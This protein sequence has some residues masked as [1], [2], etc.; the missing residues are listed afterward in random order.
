MRRYLPLHFLC[1]ILGAT[2]ALAQ[3]AGPA[4]MAI[5]DRLIKAQFE[6]K[7][8]KL[9]DDGKTPD[10]EAIRKQLKERDHH[11]LELPALQAI[12]NGAPGTS[13]TPSI[14]EGRKPSVLCF[15][16]IYKCDRCNDWH[17][18]IA[19]GFVISADGIAVTNYHVLDNAKAGAFAAMTFDGTAHIV[20]EVLAA[21]KRDDLAIVKLSGEGFKPAPL[22]TGR[23][24]EEVVAISHPQ[25]RFYTVSEGII[26]RY[27]TQGGRGNDPGAERIAIT[28]DFA[29][30]SSGCPVFNT[31]G[32]VVGVIA[33][34]N[35]IYYNRDNNGVE[36]NLQM[37]IKS[38]IPSQ[39]IQR[40]LS[41]KE[42]EKEGADKS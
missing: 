11:A 15:G 4:A 2:S 17:G 7:V 22:A 29:K 12:Q 16:N 39:A 14:Y 27:Y 31:K 8:G 35:S 6:K 21:S 23:V 20:E 25:G 10:A 38:C 28:A 24:G 36:S 41:A 19:G 3:Q 13:P 26:S 34:T 33:S 18:N 30:G 37:V 32:E 5:N 9:K 1:L 40:L 42:S